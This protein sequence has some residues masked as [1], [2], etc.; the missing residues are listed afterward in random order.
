MKILNT[1]GLCFTNYFAI[2]STCDAIDCM[3]LLYEDIFTPVDKN[4]NNCFDE[5]GSNICST[6]V[7]ET[8][9][10]RKNIHIFIA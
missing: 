9:G 3:R 8:I 10:A 5:F 6:R 1:I 2:T 4:G 7:E